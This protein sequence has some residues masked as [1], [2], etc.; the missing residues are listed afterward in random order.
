MSEENKG[1]KDRHFFSLNLDPSMQTPDNPSTLP[2]LATNPAAYP[3]SPPPPAPLPEQELT[4]TNVPLTGDPKEPA[5]DIAGE[6]K[7]GS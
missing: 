5:K 6:E 7:G 1:W 2:N 4:S 3:D